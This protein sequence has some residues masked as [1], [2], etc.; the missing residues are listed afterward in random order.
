MSLTRLP[1]VSQ[2][3]TGWFSLLQLFSYPGRHARAYACRRGECRRMQLQLCDPPA[4]APTAVLDRLLLELSVDL[5]TT[6]VRVPRVRIH[7]R[8]LY[9]SHAVSH[10]APRAWRQRHGDHPS[11][12]IWHVPGPRPRSDPN[13]QQRCKLRRHHVRH[14]P[15]RVRV[16]RIF[17]TQRLQS[18][19]TAGEFR[20]AH[21]SRCCRLQCPM[22][23]S[24]F[25]GF[26]DACLKDRPGMLELVNFT[27]YYVSGPSDFVC[28]LFV[29]FR[30]VCSSSA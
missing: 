4:G 11:G 23:S 17:K 16:I 10:A 26:Y 27:Q 24:W 12:A 14:T 21:V 3:S 30:I 15:I 8:P 19:L 22:T 28:P 13:I 18:D 1:R 5:K 20:P 2:K 25:S 9:V 29:S 7:S 6:T